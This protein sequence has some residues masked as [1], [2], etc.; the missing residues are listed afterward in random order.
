ME[1]ARLNLSDK[2]FDYVTDHLS[3]DPV[4]L[5]LEIHG[6]NLG[7]NAELAI[8]Q[9]ECRRKFARKLPGFV[10][11]DRFLFPS[12]VAG[13]QATN[14]FVA[15]YH[16]LLIEGSPDIIDMTAGLGIDVLSFAKKGCRVT[17]IELDDFKCECLEWN[18]HILGVSGVE[19]V[20]GDSTDI[21]K[22]I[23]TRNDT[24][25]F[26]DPHRRD[27]KGGRVYGLKDCLPD[28]T[29]LL[30]IWK[31]KKLKVW[32]KL[33]P[34]LDIEQTIRDL[35]GVC[36]ITA[37]CFKGECKEILACWN[38]EEQVGISDIV[39]SAV[40][41]D[42]EGLVSEFICTKE[43][44]RVPSPVISDT[45]EIEPGHYLYIPSAGMM[46]LGAWGAIC[47]KY[48]GLVKL[49]GATP[50]FTSMWYYRTFPGK[51]LT[52]DSL[53]GSSDLKKLKG[54]K[55]NVA[56]RNYPMT[57]EQLSKKAGIVCGGEDWLIG[58]KIGTKARPHLMLC[59]RIKEC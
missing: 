5:R 15:Q 14:E 1:T 27:S 45:A 37:V 36:K 9:I 33:S 21:I 52:I 16:S 24:V 22:K 7:F 28:V 54:K 47:A 11:H 20:C 55:L 13:E 48:P 8:T 25:V 57:A 29:S 56:V 49:S 46:K 42:E 6:K 19:V 43:F 31:E 23:E 26:V 59:S 10:S 18:A 32:L 3:I 35:P 2:F 51:V 58:V 30:P 4:R 34:M 38:P 53:I 41:L 17:A 50:V 44:A 39:L 40:D 12:V